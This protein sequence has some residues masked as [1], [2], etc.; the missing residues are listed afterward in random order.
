MMV[1]VLGLLFFGLLPLS[2]QAIWNSFLPLDTGGPCTVV[3]SV[4][5]NTSSNIDVLSYI[6]PDKPIN[7]SLSFQDREKFSYL[8]TLVIYNHQITRDKYRDGHSSINYTL[9]VVIPEGWNKQR[10]TVTAKS[11]SMD[12][13]SGKDKV[14][15]FALP[16]DLPA[17]TVFLR[18]IF[19]VCSGDS[20]EWHVNESKEIIHLQPLENEQLLEVTGN[21]SLLFDD[22]TSSESEPRFGNTTLIIQTWRQNSHSMIGIKE[23][24]EGYPR[25]WKWKK[26]ETPRPQMTVRSVGGMTHLRLIRSAAGGNDKNCS[27][28]ILDDFMST[29]VTPI[30]SISH[31]TVFILGA[32]CL[33]IFI[34]ARAALTRRHGG[35]AGQSQEQDQETVPLKVNR[36]CGGDNSSS[37]VT[38]FEQDSSGHDQYQTGRKTRAKIYP[39]IDCFSKSIK[40]RSTST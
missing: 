17:D 12:W 40:N 7:I 15:L 21:G 34:N 38:S 33:Y 35:Q 16:L 8:D 3:T 2:Q 37:P 4:N 13:I 5:F 24:N 39:H 1:S 25:V 14:S 22:Q 26:P 28:N 11:V 36:S 30:Y 6:T 29:M 23:K 10:L 20:P 9:P 32:A 27:S 19:S 31:V 18:G